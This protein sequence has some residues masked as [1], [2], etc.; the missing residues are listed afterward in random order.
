MTEKKDKR[1]FDPFSYEHLFHEYVLEITEAEVN[2]VLLLTKDVNTK[3]QKTT[4]EN[5]NVLNLI[6]GSSALIES[7]TKSFEP[8]EVH[9][10][11]T[12]IIPASVGS[13]TISPSGD[14]IDTQCATI[15]AYVR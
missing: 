8:F 3:D 2:Q 11:E 7:P 15:K 12:F 5:L 6:E 14:A 4:Y 1:T 9:F 10:A 13:Y